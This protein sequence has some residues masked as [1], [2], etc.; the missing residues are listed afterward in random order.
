MARSS[1]RALR[2]GKRAG[3][4]THAYQLEGNPLEPLTRPPR[5]RRD[6]P[7]VRLRPRPKR[8]CTYENKPWAP[9]RSM[10]DYAVTYKRTLCSVR[11]HVIAHEN[12]LPYVVGGACLAMRCRQSLLRKCEAQEC[13]RMQTGVARSQIRGRARISHYLI[14][15]W[16]RTALFVRH[17]RR[18]PDGA[19]YSL[20]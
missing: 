10:H 18:Q 3:D 7:H 19:E 17:F 6:R 20:V 4:A 15:N 8:A 11:M 1:V 2:A 5:Q 14:L 12:V 9:S 16:A 13:H